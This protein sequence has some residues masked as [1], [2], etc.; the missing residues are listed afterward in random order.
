METLAAGSG[1]AV[2]IIDLQVDYVS[3]GDLIEGQTSPLLQEFPDLP[4][5]VA[6]LLARAREKNI[7]V[8]HIRERDCHNKS[9]WLPWWDKLHPRSGPNCGLGVEAVAEPWSK[10]EGE[11]AVFIKHTYDAFQSGEVSIHLQEHL[12][13]LGVKRIYMAGCLTK[14]CVMFTANSAFTLGYEVVVVGDCCAD[15]TRQHHQAALDLYD[16]YHIRVDNVS[17]PQLFDDATS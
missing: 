6:A 7:P 8:I 1:S 17:S 14:A 15:R 10:E 9:V 5:N 11:E 3:G 16:G 4:T 13:S 12:K 2:M